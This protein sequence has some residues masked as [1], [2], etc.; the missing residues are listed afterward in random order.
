[1][2]IIALVV[3]VLAIAFE[4][5]IQWKYG[6]LGIVA[7][8]LLTIGIKAKNVKLSGVGAGLLVLLLAQSG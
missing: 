7:F 6:P 8:V 4:Q 1:M 3:A 2:P 5:L